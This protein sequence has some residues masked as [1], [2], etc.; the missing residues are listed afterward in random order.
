MCLAGHSSFLRGDWRDFWVRSV[1]SAVSGVFSSSSLPCLGSRALPGGAGTSPR[2]MAHAAVPAWKRA[3]GWFPDAG[4]TLSSGLERELRPGNISSRAGCASSSPAGI[5]CC[6]AALQPAPRPCL[7]PCLPLQATPRNPP[8]PGAAKAGGKLWKRAGMEEDGGE[9]QESCQCLGQPLNG[10]ENQDESQC[11][12]WGMPGCSGPLAWSPRSP[13]WPWG[14]SFLE[15][16][17]CRGEVRGSWTPQLLLGGRTGEGKGASSKPLVPS[18]SC[19]PAPAAPP[20]PTA[21]CHL[22][23]PF[24]SPAVVAWSV[25]LSALSISLFPSVFVGEIWKKLPTFFQVFLL[26][27][28]SDGIWGGIRLAIL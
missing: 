21:R 25:V 11:P 8:V 10:T 15:R 9:L 2:G 14:R 20:P 4:T 23:P 16:S 1:P 26:G 22:S 13:G 24:L 19:F 18:Q 12:A 5:L 3:P 6:G 17:E 7:I 28:V 27:L